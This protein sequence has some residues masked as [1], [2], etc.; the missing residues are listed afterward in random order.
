[1]TLPTGDTANA[2]RPGTCI[3]VEHNASCNESGNAKSRMHT[4]NKNN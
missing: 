2:E 4:G 1:M 3:E